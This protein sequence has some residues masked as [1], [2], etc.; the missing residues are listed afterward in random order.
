MSSRVQLH[1][2]SA[3]DRD[4]FI[5]AMARSRSFHGTWI[6]PPA[7]AAEFD[8]LLRRAEDHSFVSLV[9]RL[10]EDGRLAGMF[11]I[12]EIVRRAFQSAYVGYG[13]VAG[14]E[15]QGYMTEGM[16]LVLDHAFGPLALHR[17]EANIQPGNSASIALVRRCGFVREGFSE[18]YLKIGGEWRDHER[19]A[20]RAELWEELRGADTPG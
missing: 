10:R 13:G 5:E 20:I 11:S 14:L 2:L 1:T 9:I 4:E 12:S 3:D 7:T 16:G 8:Q 6:T 19:W 18:R 17:L 15:G